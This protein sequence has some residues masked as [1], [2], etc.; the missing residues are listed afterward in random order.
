MK[1]IFL[2][3]ELQPYL[4]PV[5]KILIEKH[6]VQIHIVY[7]DQNIRKKTPYIPDDIKGLFLYPRS[8]YGFREIMNVC[9][10]VNPDAIFVSGWMDYIYL[11]ITSIYRRRG[12]PIIVGFDDIW[13]GTFRQSIAQVLS[14]LFTKILFSHAW[15]SGPR[16]YEY[17]KRLGFKDR[18]VFPN[19][20]SCNFDL[21]N[22]AFKSISIKKNNYPK[23]FLFVGR[24]APEKNIKLLVSAFEKYRET[25]KG[26]W[27][28]ICIG[29]GP[30]LDLLLNHP[31]I[32]VNQF[33][34]QSEI[35]KSMA[36]SGVFVLASLKDV[37]PLVVHE[38]AC[39]GLPM[40]LSSNIGNIPLF[41]IH[42]YNGVVF[43][44]GS[45]DDLAKS[46]CLMANKSTEDLIFM[47]EKSH[48]L[49]CRITP[50]I[51]AASFVSILSS[52]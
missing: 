20:Y 10:D 1:I 29:N 23:A 37:S 36:R 13:L 39:A 52:K 34:S 44:S 14:P 32:E 22:E 12:V 27:K 43:N 47:G 7:W 6:S 35:I 38:A 28:L 48:Q 15:V 25:F 19:L 2:Y 5:F 16:Q 45:V 18:F 21:F 40:I 46:M 9:R 4:L 17:A 49:A 30:L 3:S 26:T 51:T 33:S 11:G 31:D 50:E 42:N 41:M 8:K 24:F